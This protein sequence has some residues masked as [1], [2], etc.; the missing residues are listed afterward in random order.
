M[1]APPSRSGGEVRWLRIA[2]AGY[3]LIFLT[4]GVLG[5]WA[6]VASI[7]RLGSAP[8]REPANEGKRRRRLIECTGCSG[9]FPRDDEM[10]PYCGRANERKHAQELDDLEAAAR[11]MQR[12]KDQGKLSVELREQVYRCIEARQNDLLARRMRLTGEN[13]RLGNG[14]IALVLEDATQ[15]NAPLAKGFEQQAARFIVSDKAD[16]Q[17]IHSKRR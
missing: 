12:L 15:G 14:G 11:A 6:A 4:F 8:S 2:V 10:C 17:H 1:T 16:W 5:L 13:A 3:L 7:V 9:R